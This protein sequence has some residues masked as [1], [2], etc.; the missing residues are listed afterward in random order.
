MG[1]KP[2]ITVN[3]Y[4]RGQAVYVRISGGRVGLV[5]RFSTGVKLTKDV[6]MDK[7]VITSRGVESTRAKSKLAR[8]E[9]KYYDHFSSI[10]FINE[11]Y[12]KE[13]VKAFS[14]KEEMPVSVS[15]LFSVLDAEMENHLNGDTKVQS[16]GRMMQPNTIMARQRS[17]ALL[18]EFGK[19]LDL[20][21]VDLT[22]KVTQA[23]RK[24][25]HSDLKKYYDEF[26]TYMLVDKGFK[27]KS[28][29]VNFA[30]IQTMLNHVV[31]DELFIQ[32]PKVKPAIPQETKTAEDIFV[33]PEEM[34]SLITSGEAENYVSNSPSD[35]FAYSYI[36]ISFFTT[37]RVSDMFGL[38]DESF[39]YVD[40]KMV[41]VKLNKKT[42]KT[43]RIP[44]P[45]SVQTYLEE[46]KGKHGSYVHHLKDKA[47]DNMN[48]WRHLAY[49]RL[50]KFF[51]LFSCMHKVDTVSYM[52]AVSGV[53]RHDN[54][55]RW[56]RVGTH[57]MRRTGITYMLMNGMNEIYVRMISGHSIN[58]K[59]FAQYQG[60]VKS[61]FNEDLSRYHEKIYGA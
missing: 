50:R 57:T 27:P 31:N 1:L 45:K 6:T 48:I 12:M 44:I 3:Y 5:E 34:V 14:K 42:G 56:E 25:A 55:C 19:D 30:N 61:K 16:S 39:I 29:L 36:L 52:D 20:S 17:L 13:A 53:I 23:E 51:C 47:S 43:T 22:N 18:K 38:T 46:V 49:N 9:L 33:L 32:L 41:I 35:L 2:Q 58:S 24:K 28:V 7:G 54:V 40:G 4:T 59:A 37:L 11:R 21:K 15:S 10:P 26:V 8:L 60:L